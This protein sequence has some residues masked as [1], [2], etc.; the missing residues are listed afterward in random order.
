VKRAYEPDDDSTHSICSEKCAE[1]IFLDYVEDEAVVYPRS[2]EHC[3][4]CGKLVRGS[5]ENGC[6]IHF[7]RHN[8]RGMYC[9]ITDVT[10]TLRFEATMALVVELSSTPLSDGLW[11]Y[12]ADY[13]GN[14][15]HIAPHSIAQLLIDCPE[16]YE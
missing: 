6:V 3:Y 2:C 4:R 9:P 11:D 13:V 14:N 10:K 12:A 1:L 16:L 5:F 15:A 7:E 8:P